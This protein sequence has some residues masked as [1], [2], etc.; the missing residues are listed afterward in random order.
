[1]GEKTEEPT[2]K[3]LRKAREEGDTGASGI[4][5]QAVGFCIAVAIVPSAAQALWEHGAS[6]LRRA[7]HHAGDRHPTARLD[8]L[9]FALDL[10]ALSAPIIVTTG[11]AGA[12]V[13]G[14]Q[15]GGAG[16]AKRLAPKLE[17]LDVARGLRKLA[18]GQRLFAVARSLLFAAVVGWLGVHALRAHLPD[19]AHGVEQLRAIPAL[20]GDVALTVVRDAAWIGLLFGAADL[21][22]TRR[23]WRGRLRMSKDE[24]RREAKESDG[25]PQMKAARERVHQEMLAEATL[26]NVR[27]ATVVIVN[28]THVACAL[29]YDEDAGDEAPVVVASGHGAFAARIVEA[30]RAYGVPIV[31]DVPLARALVELQAG[32]EIPEGLYEAVAEVLREIWR[33]DVSAGSGSR[34]PY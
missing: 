2:P 21:W 17:R 34:P 13:Y 26:A 4:A 12:L 25:D 30:A 9:P 15:T 6:A 14:L 5:S 11:L 32:E 16:A 27:H 29:R 31:R 19:L 7:I 28:P 8:P 20:A 18:S 10:I 3:R 24:V 22:V 23:A 1:M 33:A